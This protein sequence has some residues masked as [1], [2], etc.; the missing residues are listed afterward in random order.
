MVEEFNAN[1]A[2]HG[3]LVQLPLPKHINEQQILDAISLDK[4]VDGFHPLNIGSLAMR[5]RQPKFIS[6]TPKACSP[7]PL[8]DCN[9]PHMVNLVLLPRQQQHLRIVPSG[10]HSC[11]CFALA[12]AGLYGAA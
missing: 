7:S 2:V 3:I 1:S 5:G 4:D 9:V 8:R 12:P 10:L 11:I 6:C